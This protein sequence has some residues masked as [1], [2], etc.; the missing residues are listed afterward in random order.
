V[1]AGD[2]HE[3][4]GREPSAAA[5]VV[6]R[7]P[8]ILIRRVTDGEEVALPLAGDHV[9]ELRGTAHTLWN[10]IQGESHVDQV[11]EQ[12]AE[13]HGV[14]GGAIAHDVI[15]AVDHLVNEGLLERVGS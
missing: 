7:S 6:R 10:A 8:S 1:T 11:I 13:A 4:K 5:G 12:L 3:Y 9:V 14:D 15:V 2:E